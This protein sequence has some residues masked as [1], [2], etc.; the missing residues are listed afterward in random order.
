[1]LLPSAALQLKLP[2]MKIPPKPSKPSR[3]KPNHAAHASIVAGTGAAAGAGTSA[4]VGGAGLAI[5]GTAVSVGII[6]F[7]IAGGVL[8]LAGY[9][10]YRAFKK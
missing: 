2:E 4:V 5:G 10:V 6:P 7:A 3:K 9:G 8:A 1:M